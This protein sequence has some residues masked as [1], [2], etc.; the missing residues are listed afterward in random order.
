[1]AD[2]CL[3]CAHGRTDLH[4]V[5]GRNATCYARYDNYPAAPGHI[6][7]VPL[8]HV[9]SLFDLTAAETL[10]AHA[11][12]RTAHDLVSADG[13]TIDHLHIHFIP[14]RFGDVPDPRGGIRGV[15]QGPS[16]D[17]WTAA[18]T[19]EAPRA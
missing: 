7:V 17:L 8:R 15:L 13:Y 11:L 9:E 10:N 12:L 14:R 6:E 3:F 1:V 2:D 18:I 19:Q 5:V 16:P 4:T